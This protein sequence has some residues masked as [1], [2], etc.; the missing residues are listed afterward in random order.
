L[1]QLGTMMAVASFVFSLWL[2][3]QRQYLPEL[4]PGMF[5]WQ[6]LLAATL[7]TDILLVAAGHMRALG[8]VRIVALALGLATLLATLAG[9]GRGALGLALAIS[10]VPLYAFG[11]YAEW[12]LMRT[13][14]PKRSEIARRYG[15]AAVAAVA[16]MAYAQHAW[17]AA[18]IVVALGASGLP[19]SV[20]QVWAQLRR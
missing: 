12:S 15:C 5:A 2:P 20:R 13:S 19:G 16:C 17:I 18:A 1:A 8:V 6:A 14:A 9:A 7:P 4:M 3:N 10:A 11:F